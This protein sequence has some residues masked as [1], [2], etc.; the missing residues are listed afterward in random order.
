MKKIIICCIIVV[1]NSFFGFSE[2][3]TGFFCFNL[4]DSLEKIKNS[5]IGDL[6]YDRKEYIPHDISMGP[7]MEELNC[8]CLYLNLVTLSSTGKPKT[9]KLDQ[10]DKNGK[11]LK[12]ELYLENTAKRAH[13]D[14]KIELR[15]KFKY[16]GA[17]IHYIEF[18]FCKD[19][20]VSIR[21]SPLRQVGVRDEKNI[22][23]FY[24]T[25]TKGFSDLGDTRLDG[26]LLLKDAIAEKY[27]LKFN[28]E[29][30]EKY[31]HRF[32]YSSQ[33]NSGKIID[34]V[35]H[36]WNEHDTDISSESIQLIDAD[37]LLKESFSRTASEFLENE[38]KKKALMD[39]L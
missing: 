5:N 9:I 17:Y 1:F 37:F 14:R 12:R 11:K 16:A 30:K 20:L 6:L 23:Y 36:Y 29:K 8:H 24:Y 21:I 32:S 39:D 33:D 18:I 10:R 34:F 26:F 28:N 22:G 4:G 15:E 35:A 38:K 7:L 13:N 31:E 3:L 2:E 25:K 19:I 27:N